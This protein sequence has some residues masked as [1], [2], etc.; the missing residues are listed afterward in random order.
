MMPKEVL[1][2]LGALCF[3]AMAACSADDGGAAAGGALGRGAHNPTPDTTMMQT[4]ANGEQPNPGTSPT[5]APPTAGTGATPQMKPPPGGSPPPP[6]AM[7]TAKAYFTANV[8]PQLEASCGSCHATGVDSAPIFLASASP[9]AAYSKITS[10]VVAGILAVPANSMLILHGQHTGPALTPTQQMVVTQWLNI[11]VMER[12]LGSMGP[13]GAPVVTVQSAIAQFGACMTITDFT[14]R[15]NGVAVSDLPKAQTQAGPCNGCH[16]AGDGG[17]WASAGKLGGVDQTQ[18]MFQKTQTMPYIK[19][20]VTGT[21][22]ANGNFAGLQASNSIRTKSSVAQE[23][24]GPDCH[25]KFNLDPQLAQA[26]DDFVTKTLA[27][28][29]SGTCGTA[30]GGTPAPGTGGTI[31]VTP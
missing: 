8:D 22:D 3:A 30:A 17:F 19:K 12:H 27:N 28:V 21:V 1:G 4:P 6:P 10:G 7:A 15:S 31:P 23:C 11:E 9:D 24:V 20:Y 29:K 14:D 25:P 26:I 2:L 13:A 18:V 5:S 16:N